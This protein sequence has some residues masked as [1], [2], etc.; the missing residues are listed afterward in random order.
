MG[1]E[2]QHELGFNAASL[3]GDPPLFQFLLS[4]SS[5]WS[6]D[7]GIRSQLNLNYASTF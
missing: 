2:N 3:T 5:D 6:Y 7:A 1:N 4:S